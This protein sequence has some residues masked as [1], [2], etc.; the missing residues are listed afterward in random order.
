MKRILLLLLTV[1][2]VA[3]AGHGDDKIKALIVGT[4]RNT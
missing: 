2:S 1:A 4:W 3:M